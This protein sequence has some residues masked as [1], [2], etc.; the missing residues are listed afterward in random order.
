MTFNIVIGHFRT[1]SF[2]VTYVPESMSPH[3]SDLLV[4][5]HV[6]SVGFDVNCVLSHEL[7]DVFDAGGIGQATEA[8]TVASAAGCWKVRRR[9]E[10]RDRNDG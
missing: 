1:W 8:D 5:D 4:E 10:D 9:G 7:Q 6:D 2:T 3:Q